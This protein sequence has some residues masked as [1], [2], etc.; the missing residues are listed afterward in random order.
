[1]SDKF[2]GSNAQ[3]IESIQA[4][5]DLDAAGALVPHGV[6]GLARQLLEAATERLHVT[7]VP[8]HYKNQRI[9]GGW[10]PPLALEDCKAIAVAVRYHRVAVPFYEVEVIQ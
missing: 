9:D 2:S 1:M 10:T 8:T 4:L 7:T 3:L 6:C 5:L